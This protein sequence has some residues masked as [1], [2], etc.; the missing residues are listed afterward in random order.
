MKLESLL[1]YRNSRPIFTAWAGTLWHH[2]PGHWM[3]CSYERTVCDTCLNGRVQLLFHELFIT[4]SVV[5]IKKLLQM[6]P[7]QHGEVINWQSSQTTPRCSWPEPA[8]RGSLVSTV[9]MSPVF[10]WCP[11]KNGQVPHSRE[12]HPQT[13]G[14]Q[15]GGQALPDHPKQTKLLTQHMLNL[16]KSHQNSDICDLA[17]FTWQFILS[18]E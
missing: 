14:H 10:G 4:E 6:Q 7:A 15:P 1:S 9:S 13:A 2:D 16:S 12:R 17:H 3:L 5:I 11:G 18:W 8:S